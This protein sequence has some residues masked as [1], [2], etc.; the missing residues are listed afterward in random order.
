[1]KEKQIEEMAA[2]IE[3]FW[4]DTFHINFDKTAKALYDK[5][6]RKQS[7]GEWKDHYLIKVKCP[8]NV[9]PSVK[10]SACETVFCDIIN[11]HHFM[12]NFCPNCGAKMK[13]GEVG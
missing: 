12:Y 10:C 2:D 13:G 5:G 8:D 4:R 7:E 1:M 9:Y 11:N 6:Y 3:N